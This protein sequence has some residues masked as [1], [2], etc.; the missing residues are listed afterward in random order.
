LGAV[1]AKKAEAAPLPTPPPLA[2][3]L[4]KRATPPPAPEFKPEELTALG[5]L[6]NALRASPGHAIASLALAQVLAPHAVRR[7]DLE[8]ASGQR[9]GRA[10]PLP[11]PAPGEPDFT[12]ERVAGAF[13]AAVLGTTASREPIDRMFE[14]CA[15]VERLDD[16][17]WAL[18]ELLK[19]ERESPDPLVRYGDFLRDRRKEPHRAIERYREALMWRP[20][21]E[22]VLG[23]I[24]DIYIGEG[25][26]AFDRR[27]W[28][29]S[30]ARLQEAQKYVKNPNSP[31]GLRIRD[32][33]SRLASIR[34][35]R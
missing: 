8:K 34:T 11:P 18:E 31:Q 23:R 30:Q 28:A 9:K 14:F 17:Q 6:D 4:P 12:P 26:E 35:P 21:D 27:Q 2:S 5:F 33:Q 7:H 16:A 20:D 15:R 24:A 13:R 1:W 22:A 25:I 32:Y 3:P 29:V 19:R 10:K